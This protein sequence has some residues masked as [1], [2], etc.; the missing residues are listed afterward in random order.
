METGTKVKTFIL[1]VSNHEGL[2]TM[3]EADQGARLNYIASWF[4]PAFITS[5]SS[6][7]TTGMWI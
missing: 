4:L 5:Y 3:E 1:H 7:Y 2:S 6:A